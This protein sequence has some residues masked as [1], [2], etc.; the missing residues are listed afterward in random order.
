VRRRIE[1]EI[2]EGVVGSIIL[3]GFAGTVTGVTGKRHRQK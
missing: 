2:V 3:S 1:L